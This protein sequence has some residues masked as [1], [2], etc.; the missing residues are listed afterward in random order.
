M[1]IKRLEYIHI[2]CTSNISFARN[3]ILKF[4][5]QNSY[6]TSISLVS[7]LTKYSQSEYRVYT[8]KTAK[9]KNKERKKLCSA[10]IFHIGI[11]LPARFFYFNLADKE[12]YW[13][14]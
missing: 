1:Q 14:T 4:K 8:T 7:V 12:S 2:Y 9:Q 10:L 6:R 3:P 5:G 11:L 13:S